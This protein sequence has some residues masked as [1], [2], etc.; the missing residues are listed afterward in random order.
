[1]KKLFLL[2]VLLLLSV[3]VFCFEF[4]PQIF[5]DVHVVFDEGLSYCQLTRIEKM[6]KRSNFVR[7]NLMAGAYF[8]TIAT[9]FPIVNFELDIGAYYPFYQSFNGME[10]KTKNLISY[11]FDGFF[12]VQKTF[13]DLKY[14]YFTG[15]LGMHY[16]YQLTDEYHMHYLGLGGA[17]GIE[18]PIATN[19]TIVNRCFFSYDDANLGKNKLVQRFD[20]SYQYHITLGVRYSKK[21]QNEFQYIKKKTK[22]SKQIVFED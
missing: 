12:G 4:N 14:V 22:Q 9:G 11:A 16:M 10:Q 5:D 3:S 17:L 7:E 6:E 15:S 13:D 18:L 1:M 8:S 21:D 2:P 19:W 20:A